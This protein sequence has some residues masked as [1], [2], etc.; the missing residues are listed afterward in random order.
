MLSQKDIRE[1]R[2]LRSLR[3]DWGTL[4]IKNVTGRLCGVEYDIRSKEDLD[5]L[6]EPFSDIK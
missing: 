4:C 5:E 3:K 2:T 1:I 6:L